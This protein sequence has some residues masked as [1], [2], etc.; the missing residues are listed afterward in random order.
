MVADQQADPE[1]VI[2]ADRGEFCCGLDN[3][4]V[5]GLESVRAYCFAAPKAA[6]GLSSC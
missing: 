6:V 5:A 2:K 1:G 4:E 3:F